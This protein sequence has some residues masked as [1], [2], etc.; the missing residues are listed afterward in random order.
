MAESGKPGQAGRSTRGS[1]SSTSEKCRQTPRQRRDNRRSAYCQRTGQRAIV[2]DVHTSLSA[3]GTR[4]IPGS[5]GARLVCEGEGSS[6]AKI[7]GLMQCHSAW[8]CP[9]CSPKLAAARAESLK[10]QIAE[11]MEQGWTAH[12]LTLTLRHDFE[13]EL[14]RLFDALNDAWKLTTSGRAWADWRGRGDEAVQFVRGFDLTH[15]RHG[16]HPHLHILLLLPPGRD[17]ADW[18]LG[19][20]SDCLSEVGYECLPDALDCRKVDDP[21]AAA[22]YAVSPAAVYEPIAMAK[23]RAR[24][25]GVGLTPFEILNNAIDDYRARRRGSRWM[26]LWREYV[27]VTKGR[28]Q[29]TASRGLKL[30]PGQDE[31]KGAIDEIASMGMR[32]IRELDRARRTT[33]LLDITEM[34]GPLMRRQSVR[35]LLSSLHSKDWKIIE[36]EP[37]NRSSRHEQAADQSERPPRTGASAER[38]R[39]RPPKAS[40]RRTGPAPAS[41]S[42]PIA[43]RAREMDRGEVLRRGNA[44]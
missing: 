29:A 16:W 33:E 24:G 4:P 7:T 35:K 32:T 11:K 9:V 25:D 21:E 10:P 38:E 34:A 8:S 5:G 13:D 37:P 15:G 1:N 17:D 22:A 14:S 40:C 19:R 2:H 43:L 3:C 18:M 39:R 44:S 23:K 20:W 36:P 41:G 42:F 28:R 6:R 26:A 27:R 12:L 31:A 30:K